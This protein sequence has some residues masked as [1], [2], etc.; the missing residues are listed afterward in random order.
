VK[1][2]PL[3]IHFAKA[4]RLSVNAENLTNKRYLAQAT[5][6]PDINGTQ[7]DVYGIIGAPRA[8]YGSVSVFF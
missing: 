8:V 2:V 4:L 5:T 3:D 7:N 6:Y 1:V